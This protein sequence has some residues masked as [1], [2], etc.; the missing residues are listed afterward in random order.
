M[1]SPTVRARNGKE[2]DEMEAVQSM[3]RAHR[4]LMVV[5]LVVGLAVGWVDSAV[6]A[7]TITDENVEAA[8][9][10]AKT[11]DQHKAL[12]AYFTAKSKEALAN[13]ER[14]KRMS[15]LFSGKQG[16]GWQGH[17]QSLAKTFEE[18]AKDYAALAKEQ[19]AMAT[20]MQ[21]GM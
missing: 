18:Q 16:T 12:A 19:E 7:D 13:V 21:H 1:V 11:V 6:C 20:G 17:C 14:H 5:A 15:S 9:A 8:V 3:L 10:A 2:T 4:A